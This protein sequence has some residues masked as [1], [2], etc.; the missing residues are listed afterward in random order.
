MTFC[1]GTDTETGIKGREDGG[2]GE[3]REEGVGVCVMEC[4]ECAACVVC[5][6]RHLE[7]S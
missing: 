1:N 4:V 7:D 3:E 6:C 2:R 5:V